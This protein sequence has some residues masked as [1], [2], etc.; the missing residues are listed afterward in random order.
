MTST[1]SMGVENINRIQYSVVIPLAVYRHPMHTDTIDT[2]TH[3]FV[4]YPNLDSFQLPQILHQPFEYSIKQ[5]GECER[6]E[7]QNIR[8]RLNPTLNIHDF[9]H[10]QWKYQF[11]VEESESCCIVYTPIRSP[12]RTESPTTTNSPRLCHNTIPK[13]NAFLATDANISPALV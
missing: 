5:S 6:A 3:M 13:S 10:C 1:Q 8:F 7:C 2:Q 12:N 11:I 9:C 4:L